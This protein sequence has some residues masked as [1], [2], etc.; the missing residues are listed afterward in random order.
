MEAETQTAFQRYLDT[1]ELSRDEA[2]QILEAY[3]PADAI[4]EAALAMVWQFL[5]QRLRSAPV[6]ELDKLSGITQKLCA[7][8][9]QRRTLA[10]KEREE[11][12]KAATWD[13]EQKHAEA[14]SERPQGLS[15]ETLEAIEREL[16]LL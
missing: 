13:A 6:D 7:S 8:L 5:F 14:A 1:I 4:S 16:N 12:R 15:R 10:I 11:A 3:G 9:N 2:L